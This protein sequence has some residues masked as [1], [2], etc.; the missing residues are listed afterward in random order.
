MNHAP[1]YPELLP[2]FRWQTVEANGVRKALATA[3]AENDRGKSK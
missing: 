3:G 2:G 1:A